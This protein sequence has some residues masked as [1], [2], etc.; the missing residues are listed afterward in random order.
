MFCTQ[1]MKMTLFSKMRKTQKKKFRERRGAIYMRSRTIRKIVEGGGGGN[2]C[3]PALLGL[4]VQGALMEK[5][6]YEL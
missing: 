3:P 5:K 6:S 1:I 2:Y 4:N